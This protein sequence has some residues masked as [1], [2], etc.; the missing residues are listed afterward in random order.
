[1]VGNTLLV[2]AYFSFPDADTR[3][4][5]KREVIAHDATLK[6]AE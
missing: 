2:E 3:K 4:P 1:L 6:E 5:S